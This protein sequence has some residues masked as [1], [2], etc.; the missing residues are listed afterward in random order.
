MGGPWAVDAIEG[1]SVQFEK[2]GQ[3]ID[4]GK[5]PQP[6]MMGFP[7]FGLREKRK[8]FL[9]TRTDIECNAKFGDMNG[10]TLQIGTNGQSVEVFMATAVRSQRVCHSESVEMAPPTCLL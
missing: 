3:V 1:T 4:L 2:P 7:A 10:S 5:F 9:V 8:V 6:S